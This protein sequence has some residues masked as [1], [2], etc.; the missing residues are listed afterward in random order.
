MFYLLDELSCQDVD[1]HR[2]DNS[3]ITPCSGVDMQAKIRK[4]HKD[5][6]E[7]AAQFEAS[8]LEREDLENRLAEAEV[9]KTLLYSHR[10]VN[11]DFRVLER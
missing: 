3:T 11:A 6:N 4:M 10:G 7:V 2:V 9:R 5:A 8:K 1:N